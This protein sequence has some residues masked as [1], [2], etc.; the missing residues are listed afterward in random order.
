MPEFAF[1]ATENLAD[2]GSPAVKYQQNLAALRIVHD[3]QAAGRTV[4][5]RHEQEILAR[6]TGWGDG[7]VLRR[8]FPQGAQQAAPQPAAELGELL[9]ADEITALR[10]SSLNAHYTGLPLIRAIY[11]GLLHL[12]LPHQA[13]EGESLRVLEPAAGVGHFIGAMPPEL[14]ERSR[15]AAVELEPLAARITKLLYP[16]AQ[17]YAEAFENANLPPDWF[18]LVVSNVPFGNYRVCDPTLREGYLRASIHDYFFAKALRVTRPGGII[19]FIT[20]RYTLDKEDARLR[21]YIATHAEL[22]AAARL[23]NNAFTANAGTRVVTDLLILRKRRQPDPEAARQI[24]WRE[25]GETTILHEDGAPFGGTSPKSGAAKR[26]AA[27]PPGIG[28]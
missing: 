25:A 27:S 1:A 5:T 18:D 17:V 22:L 15:W 13:S 28:I 3:L 4:A 9:N 10:A 14:R 19:A 6:Y 26:S 20:S 24:A 2:L 8:A 7:E 11:A 12:G 16:A 23:P 21:S